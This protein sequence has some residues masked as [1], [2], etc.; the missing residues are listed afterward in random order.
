LPHIDRERLARAA[1]EA[2]T[3]AATGEGAATEAPAGA[4][5]ARRAVPPAEQEPRTGRIRLTGA[6]NV[7]APAVITCGT[8]MHPGLQ[9]AFDASTDQSAAPAAPRPP[10]VELR[11]GDFAGAGQYAAEVVVQVPAGAVGVR[12]SGGAAWADVDL[13][14]VDHPRI[15]TLL[16]GSF[17]GAFA[18]PAGQGTVSGTFN[19]CTYDGQL[20]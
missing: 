10:H 18:G 12:E 7:D 11:F 6:F 14:R 17:S 13:R 8:F 1:A 19:P 15:A 9:I 5:E 4:A 16:H 3:E 20:P 2:K